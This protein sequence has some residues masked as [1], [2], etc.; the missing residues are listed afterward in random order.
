[1]ITT[2]KQANEQILSEAVTGI[3]RTLRGYA[4]CYEKEA[5]EFCKAAADPEHALRLAEDM[6]L[7]M[8]K[9]D[10]VAP[11][12][13]AWDKLPKEER[14]LSHLKDVITDLQKQL[15]KDQNW[16]YG[17]NSRDPFRRACDETKAKARCELLRDYG[18]PLLLVMAQVAEQ[19][20]SPEG[21]LTEMKRK[22]GEAHSYAAPL[23]GKGGKKQQELIETI[24]P[25]IE[26]LLGNITDNFFEVHG[27]NEMLDA[28]QNAIALTGAPAAKHHA[29]LFAKLRD[30][31]NDAV[32]LYG[33]YL[34]AVKA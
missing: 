1:M 19:R 16:Y 14:T 5:A 20:T 28:V 26:E 27:T 11:Y 2:A 30:A 17:S 31:V 34:A 13:E 23:Q 15:Q 8:A 6:Y 10:Y 25:E 9:R 4:A 33:R 18:L 21:I 32:V 3:L 22:L 29:A 7:A 12:L 24:L